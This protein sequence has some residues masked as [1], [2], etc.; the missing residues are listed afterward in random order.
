VCLCACVCVCAGVCVCVLV[1]MRNWAWQFTTGSLRSWFWNES[2]YMRM[3]NCVVGTWTLTKWRTAR[4]AP[5]TCQGGQAAGR[6][7]LERQFCSGMHN[8]RDYVNYAYLRYTVH[9][10]AHAASTFDSGQGSHVHVFFFGIGMR[11][12]SPS[13]TCMYMWAAYMYIYIHVTSL[14]IH[15][16]RPRP[17]DQIINLRPNFF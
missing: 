15:P 16:F 10:D 9:K 7:P 17:C 11:E 3:N 6:H 5:R 12:M 14:L 2:A 8:W 4:R 1:Y 13:C